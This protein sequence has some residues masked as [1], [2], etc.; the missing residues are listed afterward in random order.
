MI[1]PLEVTVSRTDEAEDA[2]DGRAL[3]VVPALEG[4]ST[5]DLYSRFSR[6]PSSCRSN[7]PVAVIFA[8][9]LLNSPDVLTATGHR[10][11]AV[12]Q[13]DVQIRAFDGP[14]AAN[15]PGV[16]LVRMDLG[17]LE[18]GEYTLVVSETVSHFSDWN[19]PDRATDPAT[20]EHGMTFYCD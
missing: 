2:A 5:A 16:A 17:P 8:T 7:E 12:F 20:S 18:R 10:D 19:H 11:G 3:M 6:S 13:M 9:R 14:M 1:E 15:D 4:S